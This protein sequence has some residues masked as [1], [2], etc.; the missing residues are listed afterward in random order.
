MKV[1]LSSA[2]VL[3]MAGSAFAE[4]PFADVKPVAAVEP[5][6]A[7]VPGWKENLLFR[8]EIFWM[9]TAG[10]DD[11]EESGDVY[12]RISVGFEVQKRLATAT[13]T[14]ASV[15]YQGRAVYRTHVLDTAADPMGMDAEGWK[16]ETH[17]AYAEFYNLLGEP[18][19]FYVPFGLNYATDTHGTLLQLSNDR[20][21]GADR[22]WQ[23]TAYG[24]A[25]K[26]LDYAMGYVLGSGP[27]QKLD[28]Q[29]GLVVGRLG[30]GNSMLFEHGLE[31][32]VS[33]A[34]GERVAIGRALVVQPRVLIADEPTGNLDRHTGEAIFDLFEKTVRENGVS[35]VL[36]T[37]NLALAARCDR[38]LTLADGKIVSMPSSSVSPARS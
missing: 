7:P 20:V 16:Y 21:F 8:K 30:L 37:H 14:V 19:R 13:K 25:T 1:F 29:S 18:G 23:L 15:N 32:G 38:T 9:T 2:L 3:A 24:N 4:D 27:D 36:T 17:N 33:A 12:S 28:G 34:A 31:G 11:V 26:H 6:S 35:L 5:A 22:D 10:G